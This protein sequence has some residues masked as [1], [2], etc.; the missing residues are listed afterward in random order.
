MAARQ[1]RAVRTDT[2]AHGQRTI[3]EHRHDRSSSSDDDE[4]ETRRRHRL[5]VELN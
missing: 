1:G 5:G 2:R 4:E 3:R